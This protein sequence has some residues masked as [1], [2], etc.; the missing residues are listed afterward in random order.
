M[1]RSVMSKDILISS[2]KLEMFMEMLFEK[3]IGDPVFALAVVHS[4]ND[5]MPTNMFGYLLSV[6]SVYFSIRKLFIAKCQGEF[7]NNLK[8][9]CFNGVKQKSIGTIRIISEAYKMNILGAS[10][11]HKCIKKLIKDGTKVSLECLCQ[12]LTMAGQKLDHE[13]RKF[14]LCFHPLG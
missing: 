10:I 12:L 14:S 7:E 1:L 3:A 6:R 9:S 4:F 5:G 13:I 11:M 2:E 8:L